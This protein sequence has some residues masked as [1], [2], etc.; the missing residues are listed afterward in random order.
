M[1]NT[2]H[3]PLLLIGASLVASLGLLGLLQYRWIGEL[4]EAE[5][6]KLKAHLNMVAERC[7]REIDREV[8]A[9]YQAFLPLPRESRA[10]D[11]EPEETIRRRY[12][13]WR[14]SAGH[15]ELLSTI[16]LSRDR[17][18]P[19]LDV[20]I[21]ESGE[22]RGCEWPAELAELRDALA[23]AAEP[24]GRWSL[25]RRPG[26]Y[27]PVTVSGDP[28][29]LVVPLMVRLFE[30]PDAPGRP[31]SPMFL[32]LTLN[33]SYIRDVFFPSL[34][35]QHF[36][37][38]G[39]DYQMVIIDQGRKAGII[40]ASDVGISPDL[41]DVSQA[42]VACRLFGLVPDFP[43]AVRQRFQLDDGNGS[44]GRYGFFTPPELSIS[45]RP[46]DG[47]SGN[48]SGAWLLLI[49]H[50]SGSLQSAVSELRQRN[51]AISGAI[52]VVL[53]GSIF[54]LLAATRRA[55]EV[56]R[57]QIQFVASV[58]HELRTPL[59]VIRA[60]GENIADGVVTE[61]EEIRTYG[62]LVRDN[63]RRLTAMVEQIL[64]YAG[65]QSGFR[66]EKQKARVEDLIDEA[67]AACR[68]DLEQAGFTVERN[69]E[70][71]LPLVQADTLALNQALRN[72]IN[73][74]VKFSGESRR[75]R[76]SAFTCRNRRRGMQVAV[77]VSDQG[78]GIPSEE[79]PHVFE[80]FYRGKAVS[81]SRIRGN[82][83]GLSLVKGIIEDHGGAIR[84]ESREGAGSTFTV[85]LP[86][87]DT[88][89]QARGKAEG[90][91]E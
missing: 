33:L 28:P 67:I 51:L 43:G 50:R 46:V 52:L 38:G 56:A 57:R 64:G 9:L 71:D 18:A 81:Q 85:A 8:T 84:V 7:A 27:R 73:N 58:S 3:K 13:Q 26:G 53:A 44:G 30:G 22:F 36:P 16:W 69:I 89:L 77:S 19:G 62:E 10:W 12:E 76:I 29:A 34:V 66:R 2:R 1:F 37:D 39:R 25:F 90:K 45:G 20:Y 15:P 74:A 87:A 31:P 35:D 23:I 11:E 63:S 32:V 14:D 59:S 6:N 75:V 17:S 24:G 4:G 79:L 70:K 49:R 60:A 82:G 54:F 42:D 91:A 48:P 47:I 78:I 5:R 55:Q 61:S 88:S 41:T 86:A 83:L 68:P 72:L 40:Y 21:Q 80:P 65:A